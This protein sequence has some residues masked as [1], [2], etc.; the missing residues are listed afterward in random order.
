[1]GVF[2]DLPYLVVGAGVVI[3]EEAQR[4]ADI[5]VE[6]GKSLT[7]EGRKK[8][9]V[10][11][12]GLVAKGGR[13]ATDFSVA[14]AK[15]VQRTLENVG[16]VTRDD[17]KSLDEKVDELAANVKNRLRPRD[18]RTKPR[19]K[20]VVWGEPAACARQVVPPVAGSA[21]VRRERDSPTAS[22]TDTRSCSFP[23]CAA[24]S[25]R[26][27]RWTPGRSRNEVE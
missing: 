4:A 12:R 14:V 26:R 3:E 13:R 16:L 22:A 11:K 7:P 21:G 5:F 27:R 10:E 25:R 24:T 8:A 23:T 9:Q 6:K 18:V 20:C 17:L 2:S 19:Q 1:M 15:T